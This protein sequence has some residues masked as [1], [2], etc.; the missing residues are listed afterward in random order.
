M[1]RYFCSFL[2]KTSHIQF[3]IAFHVMC[4]FEHEKKICDN[5]FFLRKELSKVDSGLKTRSVQS[6]NLE[7]LANIFKL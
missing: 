3:P 6:E 2:V 1:L 5:F 7:K 4:F